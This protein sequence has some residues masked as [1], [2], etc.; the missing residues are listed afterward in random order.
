MD[1]FVFLFFRSK[2]IICGTIAGILTAIIIRKIYL[3]KKQERVERKVKES[4]EKARRERRQQSRPRARDLRDDEKCVVC[5]ENPKEVRLRTIH[6]LPFFSSKN[7]FFD[8][9]IFSISNMKMQVIC[10]P[11]GHVAMCEDCSVKIKVSCPVCRAKI[12]NKSAAFIS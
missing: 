10:L 11:C 6:I 2:V 1:F 12:D 8:L 7:C 9:V 3:R 5:V 4:L